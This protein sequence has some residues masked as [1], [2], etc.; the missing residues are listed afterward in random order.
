MSHP[1]VIQ[2]DLGLI[3]GINQAGRAIGGALEKRFDSQ[4]QKKGGNILQNA[5][6]ELENNPS[7][8]ALQSIMSKAIAAGAPSDLVQNMGSLYATLQKSQP[9]APLHITKSGELSDIFQQFGIEASAANKYDA[10]YPHLT[11]GGQTAFSNIL[12]DQIQRNGNLTTPS[13]NQMPPGPATQIPNQGNA[14]A[15]KV[16]EWPKVN[17]FSDL[18][19]REKVSRG[20]E[21]FK[22]NTTL[23]NTAAKNLNTY[24]SEGLS[25]RLLKSLNKTDKLPSGKTKIFNVDLKT[26][27]LR[28]PAAANAETQLFVKNINRFLS[29]AQQFFGGKVTN[30]EVVQY[31]Q[32]LPTLANSSEGRIL[33]LEQMDIENQLRQLDEQSIKETIGKY[34]TRGIDPAEAQ[35]IAEQWKQ[36]KEQELLERFDRVS[37][38]AN[39][40]VEKKNTPQDHVLGERKGKRGY[41]PKSEISKFEKKGGRIL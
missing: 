26:G 37:L 2:E 22:E 4:K 1:I 23:F 5:L 14:E 3:E 10:L 9:K 7:P 33:I 21:F 27:E 34:G 13:N 16:F 41:I 31:K 6:Q 20:N 39:I 8:L 40:F 17:P 30:F 19:N 36:K 11:T 18:T 24:K 29:N 15:E 12:F 28:I 38:A 32:G 25:I 35:I